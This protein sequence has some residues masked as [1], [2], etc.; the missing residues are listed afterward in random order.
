VK[1][2]RAITHAECS[3]SDTDASFPKK[4]DAWIAELLSLLEQRYYRFGK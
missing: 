4:I 2:S 3:D 1:E